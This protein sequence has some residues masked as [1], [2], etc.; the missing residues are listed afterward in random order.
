MATG[1]VRLQ[2]QQ[3]QQTGG[4]ESRCDLRLTEEQEEHLERQFAKAK[5]PSSSEYMLIGAEVGLDEDVVKKW[6][7]LKLENWRRDQGLNPRGGRI[8]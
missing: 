5:N 4:L 3:Q 7:T 8:C 2:Q 1:A 6:Y